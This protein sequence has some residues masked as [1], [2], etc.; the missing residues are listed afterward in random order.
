MV[1]SDQVVCFTLDVII[2]IAW[3]GQT[4]LCVLHLMSSLLLHGQVRP[5]RAM[6]SKSTFVL[7][8]KKKKVFFFIIWQ[9]GGGF[10]NFWSLLDLFCW[11]TFEDVHKISTEKGYHCLYK[12]LL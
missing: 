1:R 6:P 5:G 7:T 3:S 10:A 11:R 9:G 4:R 2:I 12:S 8:F